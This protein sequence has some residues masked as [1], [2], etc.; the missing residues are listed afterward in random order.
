M[1]KRNRF[2]CFRCFNSCFKRCKGVIIARTR[3]GDSC[4]HNSN[5]IRRAIDGNNT[6]FR[7]VS[8]NQRVGA[9]CYVDFTTRNCNLTANSIPTKCKCRVR[10]TYRC[11]V[12]I[13]INFGVRNRYVCTRRR[14]VYSAKTIQRGILNRNNCIRCRACYVYSVVARC[15]LYVVNRYVCCLLDNVNCTF[16]RCINRKVLNRYAICTTYIDRASRRGRKRTSVTIQNDRLID[17]KNFTKLNALKKRNRFACICCRISRF[18]GRII[19]VA[20][21]RFN[22]CACVI[23]A[24]NNNACTGYIFNRYILNCGGAAQTTCYCTYSRISAYQY[25][26]FN[27][28]T[29]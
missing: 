19:Y 8:R 24:T 28:A 7:R 15:C 11:I 4:Y 1:K 27:A 29:I 16:S 23:S 5:I 18:E 20:Y 6:I 9:S 12:I 13:A 26:V 10:L 2:A 3:I 14:Y 17:D 21:L 25:N 22:N